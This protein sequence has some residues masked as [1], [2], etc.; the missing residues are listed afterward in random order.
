MAN[1]VI[2]PTIT[3]HSAVGKWDM[4]LGTLAVAAG[5]YPAGGLTID[6]SSCTEIKSNSI[7][8]VF[9]L[10]GA[11]G[12]IYAYVKGATK[13]AGLLKILQV[14]ASGGGALEEPS[15][16]TPSG[17]VADTISFMALFPLLK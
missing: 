11:A 3:S 7:P 6:F 9:F 13:N 17:V 1:S 2:T 5:D 12:Y 4:I 16:T 8:I 10:A 14:P 15:T